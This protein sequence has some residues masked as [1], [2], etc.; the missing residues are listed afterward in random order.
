MH[1][2]YLEH[3]GSKLDV[4]SPRL[5]LGQA[6]GCAI[7]LGEAADRLVVC[8]GL[9][10]GLTLYQEWGIPVWVAGGA[11]F[12]PGMKI[13]SQINSLIV[14]ADNDAAGE[15]A[16]HRTVDALSAVGRNMSIARPSPGFKDFNDQLR[17]RRS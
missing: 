2:T 1:R 3:G 12:M 15:R 5:T 13:P 9:E 8:E 14:A 7:R 11:S 4:A 6:R 10:D 16:A 17:G